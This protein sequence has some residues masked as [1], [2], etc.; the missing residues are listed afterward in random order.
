MLSLC[1]YLCV[2][3]SL[4]SFVPTLPQDKYHK[5]NFVLLSWVASETHYIILELIIILLSVRSLFMAFVHV[6]IHFYVYIFIYNFTSVYLLHRSFNCA[7][8]S[9]KYSRSRWRELVTSSIYLFT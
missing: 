9:I 1:V 5:S 7:D 6:Y 2:Y 8:I 4:S 3:T